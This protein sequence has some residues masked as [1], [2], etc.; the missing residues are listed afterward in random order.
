L[1]V[2]LDLTGIDVNF[3]LARYGPEI[4]SGVNFDRGRLRPNFS[5]N[6]AAGIE[7]YRK[8]NRILTLQ[9]AADN[10]TDRIN[11]LNFAGRFS[12]TAVAAPRSAS[13]HLRFVF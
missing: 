3:L 5:L 9:V 10:L 2:E 4:L 8:E 7:L 6:A 11:V 12:G 1:P 13:A